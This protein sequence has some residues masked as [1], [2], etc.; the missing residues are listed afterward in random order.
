MKPFLR[1]AHRPSDSPFGERIW[2]SRSEDSGE[3]VSIAQPN[4]EMV[5]TRYR[6]LTTLTVRGPETRAR[7]L[8]CPDGGEWV[9]VRFTLG[10]FWPQLPPGLLRDGQD[11]TLAGASRRAFWL[12]GSAWE[13][14]SF[15]NADVFVARLVRRGIIVRDPL[16]SG[17]VAGDGS[18]SSVRSVQRHFARAAG[19]TAT[20]VHSIVRAR[21]AAGLLRD[22]TPILDVVHMAG[23]YDQPHLTRSLTRLMGQTPR[24]LSRETKQLSFLYKT[25]ATSS[26]YDPRR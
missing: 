17:A 22:G 15:E 3:M 21:H 11:V 5:V 26:F 13:Y 6:G 8:E 2:T 18:L 4:W 14:P 16:L 19:I 20:S 10:T 7:S 9:G 1:F 25:A 23:Y 12:N 24:E